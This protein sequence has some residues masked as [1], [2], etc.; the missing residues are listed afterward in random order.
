V[1]HQA[2]GPGIVF[3][4]RVADSGA[5]VDVHFIADGK[6]RAVLAESL[7]DT[8]KLELPPAQR[9]ALRAANAEYRKSHRQRVRQAADKP[10]IQRQFRDRL[11]K[12]EWRH[13]LAGGDDPTPV[14][15]EISAVEQSPQFR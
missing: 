5:V 1:E 2:F 11:H 7:T 12:S 8:A 14:D 4:D 13:V 15:E 6:T 3:G 10:R 9:K